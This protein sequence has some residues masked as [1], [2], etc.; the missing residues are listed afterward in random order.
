MEFQI[1]T[2][3]EQQ[4]KLTERVTNY[5]AVQLREDISCQVPRASSLDELRGTE[6]TSAANVMQRDLLT[7]VRLIK[8]RLDTNKANLD[9]SEHNR[10]QDQVFS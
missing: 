10:A 5:P 4:Y 2:N 9:L 1:Y 3:F 6:Q 7:R 8:L